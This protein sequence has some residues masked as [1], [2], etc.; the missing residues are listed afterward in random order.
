[1][2]TPFRSKSHATAPL[3]PRLPSFL[4]KMCRT[5]AAVRFRLSVNASTKTAT[6]PS[7]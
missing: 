4:A 1:M 3:V 2:T 6:P 5:S 7:P